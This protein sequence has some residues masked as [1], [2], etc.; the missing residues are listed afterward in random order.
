[1]I[2]RLLALAGLALASPAAARTYD[3]RA[4][5]QTVAW[6][7]YDATDKPVLTIQ[8]DDTMVIHTLLTSNPARLE[9]AVVAPQDM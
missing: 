2:E 8:S 1:M 5:P 9:N 3:L 7:H 6:G 4:T